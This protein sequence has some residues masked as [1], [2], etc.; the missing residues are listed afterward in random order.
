MSATETDPPRELDV[1]WKDVFARI[2]TAARNG[3][4]RVEWDIDNDIVRG[5]RQT[6][7]EHAADSET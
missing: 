4:D 5:M 2:R 3:A 6:S 1:S 7:R